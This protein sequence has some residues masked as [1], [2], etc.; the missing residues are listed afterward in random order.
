VSS[1]SS[2]TPARPPR[3]PASPPTGTTS[4]SSTIITWTLLALWAVLL[5]FGVVSMA[6]PRWLRDLAQEG[7][8]A[9]ADAYKHLGDTELK[10]GHD[11][12]AIAQYVHALSIDA[13]QP[14]VLLNLGIAYLRRGDL[15]RAESSLQQA[16]RLGPSARVRP[17]ISVNLGE[18]AEKQNRQEVAIRYYEQALREGGRQDLVYRKLGAVYLAQKDHARAAEAFEKTLA[19]QTD[20]RLAYQLMLERTREV[21]E[22]DS[23]ARRWV[24]SEAARNP[25]EADWARFD[26]ESIAV[27]NARDP[28]IAKTHNHLGLIAHLRGDRED[29]IHHFEQSLAIWPGN[30]D[31]ARILKILRAGGPP[32]GH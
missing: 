2:T 24:E 27:M 10:K 16:S 5:A 11:V 12:L 8:S 17:Y 18:V 22:K 26:R 15:A 7:R 3:N 13:E 28:E 23:V 6:N 14:D 30:P 1:S 25:S 19:A 9:E 4:R 31:A 21:A 20:P 29:A 32:G